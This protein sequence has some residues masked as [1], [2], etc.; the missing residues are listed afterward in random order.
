MKTVGEVRKVV[1]EGINISAIKVSRKYNIILEQARDYTGKPF[2]LNTC[3]RLSEVAGTNDVI[4]YDVHEDFIL[5]EGKETEVALND[6]LRKAEQHTF[7]SFKKLRLALD[8]AKR[9][10]LA[11]ICVVPADC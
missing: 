6:A 11:E 9:L 3:L 5:D 1:K 7:N 10:G 4:I 8:A 2:I